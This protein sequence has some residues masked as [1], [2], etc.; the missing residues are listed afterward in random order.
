[1]ALFVRNDILELTSN[2]IVPTNLEI[3]SKYQ[4]N[5]Q[6]ISQIVNSENKLAFDEDVDIVDNTKDNERL[7]NKISLKESNNE[8]T[9]MDDIIVELAT[10]HIADVDYRLIKSCVYKE[11]RD[12]RS[13]EQKIFDEA[14]YHLSRYMN[15]DDDHYDYENDVVRVPVKTIFDLVFKQTEDINEFK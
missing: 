10:T 6:N 12:D 15:L 4:S 9:P 13:R 7:S 5:Q 14:I 1:M 8:V 2:N 11:N 3:S